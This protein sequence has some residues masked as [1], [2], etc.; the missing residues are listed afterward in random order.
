VAQGIVGL[1]NPGPEYRN[2][3]HNVGQRV[4][5]A[6]A[7]RIHAR[8][9]RDGAHAVAHGRWQGETLL[10]IK[11][12]S[13]MNVTGPPVLRL[14]RKLHLGPA[15]LVVVF[16]DLDLPLGKVR[17]RLKGS[18][19]GHNGVRS[20]IA[21][22]GTDELRR[23]KIGIGRPGRPGEDRDQ[24]SD[25]V[26]SPFYPEE[27]DAIAAACDEAAEQALKLVERR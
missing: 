11:P 25:H 18:A 21:A 27:L 26:L 15:D 8:F 7:R 1:G 9:V 12:G 24:V 14:T 13:F 17:V 19:G 20:L 6:L 16:D 4:V 5:D 3:R 22:F 10:L 23:V 2:T